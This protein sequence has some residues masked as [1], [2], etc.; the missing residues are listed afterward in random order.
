ML[1]LKELGVIVRKWLI[2][3]KGL[4]ILPAFGFIFL[5]IDLGCYFEFT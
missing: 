4:N 3:N 1:L 5:K 2:S